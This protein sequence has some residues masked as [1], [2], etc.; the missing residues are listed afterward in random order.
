MCNYVQTMS[1][2]GVI[3]EYI[4]LGRK[5]RDLNPHLLKYKNTWWLYLKLALVARPFHV[6][7]KGMLQLRQLKLSPPTVTSLKNAGLQTQETVH[8]FCVCV[9][10]FSPCAWS[11]EGAGAASGPATVWVSGG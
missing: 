8:S 1:S 2:W 4:S 3:V 11:Q 9:C 7:P 5:Y 6:Q 10:V